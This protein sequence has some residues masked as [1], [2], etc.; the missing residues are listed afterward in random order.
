MLPLLLRLR[1]PIV[2]VLHLLLVPLGYYMAF[3][4]RF[5]FRPPERHIDLYWRTVPYLMVLRMASFAIFGLFHG[6]WR[7]VGMRDLIDLVRATTLSSVLLLLALF[8][9]GDLQVGRA[10]PLLPRSV[11]VLDW[12]TALVLFGGLRFGVR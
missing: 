2:L 8:M 9:T 10:G 6:W 4:L 7:H 11:L 3:A 1:R 5:D 12:I